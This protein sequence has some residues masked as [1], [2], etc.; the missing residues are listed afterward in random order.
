[1][2]AAVSGDSCGAG[3]AAWLSAHRHHLQSTRPVAVTAPDETIGTATSWPSTRCR[4]SFCCRDKSA[5]DIRCE[6]RREQ[7]GNVIHVLQQHVLGAEITETDHRAHC[8]HQKVVVRVVG[9]PPGLH[10]RIPAMHETE[11]TGVWARLPGSGPPP[12]LA[13]C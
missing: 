1:M 11:H 13:G 4:A 6:A 2:A 9:D 7:D 5:A 8:R 10:W 3:I 12:Q